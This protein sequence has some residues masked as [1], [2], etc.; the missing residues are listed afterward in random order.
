MSGRHS[1]R[2]Q[3]PLSPLRGRWPKVERHHKKWNV[4]G[5]NGPS[6]GQDG[7]ELGRASL[8][9]RQ[10]LVVSGKVADAPNGRKLSGR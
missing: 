10:L 8:G 4:L 1:T 7:G 9:L 2:V 5:C 3:I 6:M